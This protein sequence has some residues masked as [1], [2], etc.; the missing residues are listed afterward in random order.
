MNANRSCIAK[1]AFIACAVYVIRE[2]IESE[3]L[4]ALNK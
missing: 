4:K 2:Q 3:E 1:L